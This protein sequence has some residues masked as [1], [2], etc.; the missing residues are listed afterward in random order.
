MPFVSITRLRL[1]S[2]YVL[3]SFARLFLRTRRQIRTARGFQGGSILADRSWVFWTMTAWDD[4]EA[5]R[6]YMTSGAH[7]TAMPRLLDWCDEAAVVHWVHPEEALP[8]WPEAHRRMRESGRA[9]KVRHPSPRHA[10][11]DYPEPRLAMAA[12][13]HPAAK[14]E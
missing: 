6:D 5:M 10:T 14:I 11:L 4:Q 13:I 2:V 7:R 9:S 3:P 12:P 1:R 8:S